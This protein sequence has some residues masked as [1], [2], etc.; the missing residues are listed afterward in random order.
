LPAIL[1]FLGFVLDCTDGNIARLKKQVSSKGALYDAIV[2]RVAFSTILIVLAVKVSNTYSTHYLVA[3]AILLL[4]LMIIFDTTRRRIEKIEARDI[5]DTVII[6]NYELKIKNKL[7]K[8]IPF[9]N[10]NNVII[11]IGA[12]LEWT[13]LLLVSIF[14]TIFTFIVI[15]L[16]M[17]IIGGFYVIMFV[18]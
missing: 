8:I 9:I 2:D 1:I 11:G 10:W 5:H 3:M 15:L 4:A 13:L 18:C 17:L 7:K 6:S 14:P 12:D 16:I